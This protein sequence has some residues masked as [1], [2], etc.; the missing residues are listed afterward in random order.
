MAQ[1]RSR[2]WRVPEADRIIEENVMNRSNG[3]VATFVRTHRIA[4]AAIAL[5]IGASAVAGVAAAVQ[6]Y[7]GTLVDEFGN[8]YDVELT[9]LGDGTYGG[10]ADGAQIIFQPME[11]GGGEVTVELDGSVHGEEA[12]VEI[13][14]EGEGG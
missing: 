11:G 5:L 3:M 4:A 8:E 13:E 10:T 6:S 12:T 9:P 7:R 1:L 2:S 14:P